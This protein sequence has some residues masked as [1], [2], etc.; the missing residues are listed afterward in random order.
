LHLLEVAA[1]D[2][3][4]VGQ[5]VRNQEDPAF[6][7]LILGLGRGRA[8]GALGDYPD[9]VG[10]CRDIVICNLMLECCGNQDLDLS[11]KPGFAIQYLVAEIPSL[12]GSDIAEAIRRFFQFLKIDPVRFAV[13]HGLARVCVPARYTGHRTADLVV[14]LDGVL[15]D[16]TEAL[17]T[18]GCRSG[19]DAK[20]LERLAEIVDEAVACRLQS[21]EGTTGAKGL[22]GD[23]ARLAIAVQRLVFVEHP[24][25][26]LTDHASDAAYPGAANAFDFSRAEPMRI[27][28]YAAHA[29]AKRQADDGG[30]PCRPHGE[31]TD[32]V[33]SFLRVKSDAAPGGTTGVVVLDAEPVKYLDGSV[34]ESYRQ[35]QPVLVGGMAKEFPRRSVEPHEIGEAVEFGLCVRKRIEGG[36]VTHGF[37]PFR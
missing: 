16:R 1:G 26:M 9:A 19:L 22:A 13:R 33:D 35:C 15:G 7:D 10:N 18:G 27:A 24:G 23:R 14:E 2:A 17:N 34:I 3:A 32:G 30:F 28:D 8:V 20:F 37:Y 4:G 36:N 11:R 12:V 21:S 5:D 29:A 6:D 25:H 31:R